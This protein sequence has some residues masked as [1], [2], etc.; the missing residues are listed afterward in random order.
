MHAAPIPYKL[1]P[2]AN[3]MIEG[4]WAPAYAS[5]DGGRRA[6]IAGGFDYKIG[7]CVPSVDLYDLKSN[8]F[9]PSRG[10]LAYPRDFAQ[11]VTLTDGTVLIAGGFND[12]LGSVRM[13]EI[14][15]PQTDTFHTIDSMNVPRE[16]FQAIRLSDGRVLAIGGLCTALHRTVATCEIYDP[17]SGK[18]SYTSSMAVD[19]FG[20]AACLLADGRVFVAGGTSAIMSRRRGRSETLSSAEIY[21]PATGVFTTTPG[22]LS[23]ARDR[24]TATLLPSG[25]VLVAGGQG[26]GGAPVKFCEV[27]DPST[28]RFAR[29]DTPPMTPRMAH[30][31]SI[32][33]DGRVLLAGGWDSD[34][35]STTG[36]VV[37]VDAVSDSV[38]I[39]P[40]LPFTA[41]DLAQVPL[42]GDAVLIA[43]GKC[44]T[45]K[46]EASSV[47]AGALLEP[48]LP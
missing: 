2:V 5:I 3:S 23:A 46:G 25:K 35:K 36:T 30:A 28:G 24:P 9:T 47:D 15:D 34:A 38:D 21:N 43:G 22:A 41:H 12:V 44:V 10:R 1:V 26:F 6:F 42:A 20:H 19:R 31:A 13:A 14:Y 48:L 39:F 16:L 33:P 18:W 17:T 11:A 37:A 32:L 27:F 29:L 4:R 8:R 40:T 45:I 7:E